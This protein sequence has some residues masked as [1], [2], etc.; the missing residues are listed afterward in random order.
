MRGKVIAITGAAR[1]IGLATARLL[2]ERGATVV[3]GDIDEIELRRAAKELGVTGLPLDVTDEASF[4]AFLTDAENAHGPLDVLI[5]N[6]GIMPVGPIE[7][8]DETLTRRTIEID[9]LGVIRGS[10]L[11]AVPMAGRGR[12]HIV[13]VASVAGRVA[14]PG[15]AVY[16]GAKHGVIGFSEALAAELEPHGVRV[17]TVLPTF[18]K[19]GLIDGIAL[20]RLG[21]AAEPQDVARAIARCIDRP[22]MHVAVPWPVSVFH[23]SA[24]APFRLKRL[25]SRLLGADRAFMTANSAAR[26]HHSRQLPESTAAQQVPRHTRT[27]E[28]NP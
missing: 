7:D 12:G 1:G 15:L 19:T 21:F 10:R 13:N 25:I 9:L 3:I 16:T 28:G 2:R 27:T 11:V 20:P 18:T 8:F 14:V 5:N 26:A 23:S 17:S 6:A 24:L 22:R 4:A